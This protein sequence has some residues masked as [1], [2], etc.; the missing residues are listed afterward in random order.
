MLISQRMNRRG[1]A[2]AAADEAGA[3]EAV[4]GRELPARFAPAGNI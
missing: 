2:P 4:D 1:D 3:V